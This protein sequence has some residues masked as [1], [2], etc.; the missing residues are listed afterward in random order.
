MFQN[1][2]VSHEDFIYY[3]CLE[4]SQFYWVLCVCSAAN[5]SKIW[6]GL[7]SGINILFQL[8]KSMVSLV[9]PLAGD[10]WLTNYSS[11]PTLQNW[12]RF[13]ANIWRSILED[14]YYSPQKY[15]LYNCKL[16]HYRT[17]Y[18][19]GGEFPLVTL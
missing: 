7:Q 18:S 13:P 19:Q 16:C 15:N 9:F 3:S 5:R 14:L 8:S 12:I 11:F 4:S 10:E 1:T 17:F 6:S 2:N